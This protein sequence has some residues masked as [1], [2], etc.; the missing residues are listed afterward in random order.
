MSNKY[1]M[2]LHDKQ[3][4]RGWEAMQQL[5]DR[6][7]PTR[8]PKRPKA[9]WWW[10]ALVVGGVAAGYHMW[11]P[12]PTELTIP[13]QQLAGDM[14]SMSASSTTMVLADQANKQPNRVASPV[15]EGPTTSVAS[16]P[17]ER[18]FSIFSKQKNTEQVAVRSEVAAKEEVFLIKNQIVASK[19]TTT[20]AIPPVDLGGAATALPHPVLAVATLPMSPPKA[21][22]STDRLAFVSE[23]VPYTPSPFL[24][25]K[26]YTERH[27]AWGLTAG[28]IA[29]EV[30]RNL[31][32]TAGVSIDLRLP[33][34]RFGVR[35]GLNYRFQQLHSQS[36][37]VVPVAYEDYVRAA[38]AYV[39][40]PDS[41][42]TGWGYL[43]STNRVLI[44]VSRVHRLD[45]PVLLTWKATPRWTLLAG[46]SFSRVLAARTTNRGLF[47]YDLNVVRTPRRATD[48]INS[49]VTNQLPT[50]EENWQVGVN[51]RLWK[52]WEMSLSYRRVWG[53]QTPLANSEKILDR[54]YA[55][56]R[57]PE[58]E[59]KIKQAIQP[60]SLQASLLFRLGK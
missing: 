27:R 8:S 54:C 19:E 40:Q 30:P 22:R 36:R 47:T 9:G 29:M 45:V 57:F 37:L 31:G 49:I 58:A 53:N 15:L 16:T 56:D 23:R 5:L 50:W 2:N 10:M 55:C 6:E 17:T 24:P 32:V 11:N 60:G 4:D 18:V 25:I 38:G 43:A 14:A 39:V 7:M 20:A 48:E 46:I 44:P 21:I 41:L 26:K 13:P 33:R 59:E 52:R 1:D 51:Y 35:T 42:P 3:T 12:Q 34:K 28:L